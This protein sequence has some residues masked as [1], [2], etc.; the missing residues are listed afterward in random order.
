MSL[1]E[2]LSTDLK[3]ALKA[4]DERRKGTLRFLMAAVH[5]AEIEAGH[6]LD[7]GGVAG[8]IAKQVKQRRDSI[9]EFR[10]GG[11]D[12]LVAS[13]EAEIAVLLPY[14]PQQMSRDE[15]VEAA[16]R[17]IAETGASAPGDKGKV[18]PV[19][20]E[21]LRGRAEGRQINEVVTELLAGS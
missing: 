2:Q 6:E 20:I 18:M 4:G 7:D 14:L 13:E 17:V 9:E 10:K 8:V 3:D 19:L 15:I 11:R 16:K 21:Q 5:N 12:D 1:K